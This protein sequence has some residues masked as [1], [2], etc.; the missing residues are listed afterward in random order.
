M[1]G[2]SLTCAIG[3]MQPQ[4]FAKSSIHMDNESR[5]LAEGCS[6]YSNSVSRYGLRADGAA[7]LKAQ[8]ICSTGGVLQFKPNSFSPKPLNDC[9]KI[10]DPLGD[11]SGPAYGGCN[12]NG[13]VVTENTDLKPGVYCSG[14]TISGDANVTLLPGIYVI[15]DG[16]FT[17]ADTASITGVGVSF[18]LTGDKSTFDFQNGTSIDL[19]AME[20]GALAGILLFEDR[21]VPY[22]FEFNPFDL[23]NLP[24]DVRLNKISS[25]NA[26]NLL[27]TIYLSRSI[28]LID[29]EA[30]VADESAYTAIITGR[31]WLQKGP[32]LSLNANFTETKVPVPNG[33]M[34]T[35]PILVK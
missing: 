28:L 9:P 29:A 32:I 18:Y 12:E 22:S 26:R 4:R 2:D 25:N 5:I 1:A 24:E 15:K 21:N 3:L 30:E 6:I 16:P 17:V 14:L 13:L 35:E 34:G 31:L 19:S 8:S 27:G 20:T 23:Y 10:E 33:L 11:R 7:E